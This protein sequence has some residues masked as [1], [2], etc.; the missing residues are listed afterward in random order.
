LTVLARR[1]N[2]QRTQHKLE[3]SDVGVTS[4]FG[5]GTSDK[6]GRL[7]ALSLRVTTRCHRHA[8][9]HLCRWVSFNLN[10]LYNLPS[11]E[12]LLVCPGPHRVGPNASMAVVCLS[13]CLIIII[14]SFIKLMTMMMM[15]RAW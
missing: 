5:D 4:H 11:Y 3:A 1:L 2:P 14:I 6:F 8:A 15:S 12:L 13:V 7:R 10:H 9:Q